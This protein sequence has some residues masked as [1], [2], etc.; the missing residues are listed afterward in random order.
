MEVPEQ[1]K[2]ILLWFMFV[3]DVYDATMC[4]QVYIIIRT[5]YIGTLVYPSAVTGTF[6]RRFTRS[7]QWTLLLYIT[8]LICFVGTFKL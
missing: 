4:I 3:Y 7:E 1:I 8:M 2:A 5:Y 6:K